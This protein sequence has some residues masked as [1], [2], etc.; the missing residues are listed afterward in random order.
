M[1]LVDYVRVYEQSP[2]VA[3]TSSNNPSVFGQPVTLTATLNPTNATCTVQF[4]DGVTNLGAP[5]TVSNGTATLLT[6]SLSVGGHSIT[7]VYSGDSNFAGSTS[8]ALGQNVNQAGS[9]TAVTSNNPSS[10][11]Q[12]VTFTATVS[13]VE[14][15]CGTPEGSVR[16]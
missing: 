14:A 6:S 1:V 4:L 13:A 12:T 5:V 10:F 8:P 16:F 2:V 15:R 3:V 7:A 9:A 11:G